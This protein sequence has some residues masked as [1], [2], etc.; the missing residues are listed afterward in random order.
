MSQTKEKTENFPFFLLIPQ[1][2]AAMALFIFEKAVGIHYLIFQKI[3]PI[4]LTG[5]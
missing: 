2:A 4:F 5:L 1:N 3:A